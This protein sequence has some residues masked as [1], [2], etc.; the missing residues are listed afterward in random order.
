MATNIHVAND[1]PQQA[2][3]PSD[4]VSQHMLSIFQSYAGARVKPYVHQA[5]VWEKIAA[6]QNTF[7]VAG[8]ASGKTLAAAVPL[9]YKLFRV[10]EP[11]RIRHALWIYPTIALL[12][13][14]R[15]VFSDL[16]N[17]LGRRVVWGDAAKPTY[18]RSQ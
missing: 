1:L 15:R 17:A 11:Q 6:G 13:D 3:I 14:Q 4:V 18:L 10:Q 12:E 5:E 8:T 2:D 9:F 16:S 7:V